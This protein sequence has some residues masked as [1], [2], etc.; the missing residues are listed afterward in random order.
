MRRSG[1]L[2]GA[3]GAFTLAFSCSAR[4]GSAATIHDLPNPPEIS[5]RGG[6]LEA[7][8]TA[9]PSRV[10]V[11]GRSFTSN[12]FNNHYTAPTLRVRRGDE[13]RLRLRNRIADAAVQIDGPELTNVHYHGMDV[14][15]VPPGDNVYIR[16]KP[17]GRYDYRFKVPEDHPEGL[18]W[19][20]THLHG[21]V[22]PQ[23]LSG[24]SGMIIVDGGIRSHYPELAH[25]R[26]RV[27]QLKANLLPGQNPDSALTKTINGYAD[28]PIR[29]RPGQMQIWELGNIGADAFFNLALEGH[30]FWVLERDGNFLL[31]PVRQRTLFLPPG[32]RTLVVVRAGKA[33]TYR[34][35]SLGT[36]TG[37]QGD[38]NPTVQLGS[39][40]VAGI[41]VDT[42][43]LAQRLN[44]PAVNV[45]K[46]TPRPDLLR[47]LP[48]K[49]KR[50]Y[51]FSETADG[52]TFFINGRMYQ[53]NRI[54][55]TARIGDLEEWTIVNTS[56]ELH[57]FHIHQMSFLVTEVNGEQPDY[58][59]LR[60]VIDI[61][62]RKNGKP[63][64]VKMLVPFLNPIMVG[65]FVYHCHI[66]GHEDAGMMANIRVLPRQTAAEEAWDTL[67]RFAG[68]A[69]PVTDPALT[70]GRDA[71]SDFD[72]ELAANICGPGQVSPETVAEAVK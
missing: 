64:F 5:S 30:E 61:P 57:V 60:D 39:F 55:T 15:P 10:R 23:I 9:A 56:G 11:A 12:V 28:P 2:V 36:D 70:G 16:V 8:L 6:V 1:W 19:Y 72:A 31:K 26:Q 40:I 51:V 27:M 58:P 43:A 24:L 34:L 49:R 46:L 69:P 65:E 52:N 59:G 50:T 37:P 4:A 68:L 20:H 22:E 71:P 7:T 21:K 35:R 47:Q 41:P 54:D 67:T 38:P 66:V 63:G 25:L 42:E 48:V 45:G 17:G 3:V 33:G 62:Y 13:I 29:S 44:K 14:T 32:A 18:H 53:E